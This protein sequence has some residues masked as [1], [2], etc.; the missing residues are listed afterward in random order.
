MQCRSCTAKPRIPRTSGR[1]PLPVAFSFPHEF[2]IRAPHARAAAS[3]PTLLQADRAVD[4]RRPLRRAHRHSVAGELF[5]GLAVVRRDRFSDS[6]RHLGDLA[7]RAVFPRRRVRLRLPLRQR[8][9]R[10]G[11]WYR[12]PRSV[13]EPWRWRDGRYLAD[14]HQALFPRRACS[15]LCDCDFAFRLVADASQRNERRSARNAGS[16][17]HPRHLVLSLSPAADLGRVGHADNAH[18]ALARRHG[19]DVLAAE[20]HHTAATTRVGKAESSATSRWT[21]GAAV[22]TAGDTQLD[23]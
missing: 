4:Y 9:N 22:R 14:V 23:R 7:N 6:V 8:A 2:T 5:H 15:L 21:P 10:P 3:I 19:G 13:R 20:R 12:I 16:T 18:A 1:R 17:L 11:S